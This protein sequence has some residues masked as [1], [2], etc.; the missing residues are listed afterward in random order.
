MDHKNADELKVLPTN[1]LKLPGFPKLV[2]RKKGS[3]LFLA[4]ITLSDFLSL[5]NKP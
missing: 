1:N 3:Q 5:Q 2:L 4:F